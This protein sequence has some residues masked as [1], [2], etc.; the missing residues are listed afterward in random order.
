MINRTVK[1]FERC[2]LF[3]RKFLS[4]PKEKQDR[5]VTSAMTLFGEVG[6][7]KAYIS[8]VA[9]AAG[10]SKALVFHYFGSKKGLY[11]YLVY[12]TGKIVVTEAQEKRDTQNKDFF[13]RALVT[14]WFR[15]SIKSRYPAMS[16]FM[17][18]VFN[19]DEDEVASDIE[20]LLAIAADMHAKTTLES[21]EE[22]IFKD[23]VDPAQV[24][25]LVEV[26][27]EGVVSGWH[28]SSSVD[29]TVAEAAL[30]FDMLKSNLCR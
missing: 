24:V 11:S 16:M 13:E 25:R 2:G 12:Y 10:I 9:A 18:S 20:R 27:S 26:Y 17:D 7:K 29:E 4:L 8:E 3:M 22:S 28:H 15:L 6:Y 14:L 5:I 21:G 1:F 23:G 19:E 30:C